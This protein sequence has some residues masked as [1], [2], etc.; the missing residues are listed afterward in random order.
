VMIDRAANTATVLTSGAPL[1]LWVDAEGLAGFV[2]E[3][4]SFPLGWF[5][6]DSVRSATQPLAPGGAFWLWSDGL[7]AFADQHELGSATA[8]SALMLAHHR[9]RPAADL[10]AALDDILVARVGLA[11]DAPRAEDFFPLVVEEYHGGQARSID[12]LQEQ[13][14]RSLEFCLPQLSEEVSYNVLL[15][16]REA[17]INALQHGCAGRADR[18]ARFQISYH[19]AQKLIRAQVHDPGPGHRFDLARHEVAAYEQLIDAHR[20]LMIMHCMAARV[21]SA[22]NGASLIMD[23]ALTP[24]TAASPVNTVTKI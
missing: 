21:V 10:S 5:P 11:S 20:G 6:H 9:L 3:A 18:T 16:S 13:W 12:S 7:E 15:C 8:A 22:R 4:G 24:E 17:V 2:G 19:P 23:F 1:P 14:R